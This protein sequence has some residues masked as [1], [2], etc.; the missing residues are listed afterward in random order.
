M[1][2]YSDASLIL[3]VAPEYK[4]GKI[5]SLKPTNGTGDFTVARASKKHKINSDLKLEIIN[6]DVPAFNYRSVDGCPVL[7][8]E[9]QA[10]NLI[11]YPISF[12]NA[13][14]VKSGATI[15]DNSGAGYS[16]PSV[17]FPTSAF[18]LVEDSGVA[19]QHRMYV[20]S[21]SVTTGLQYTASVYVKDFS[22]NR[23]IQLDSSGI[24]SYFDLSTLAITD[25]S[26]VGK[27]TVMADGWYRFEV[28]GVATITGSATLYVALANP[29]ETYTGDGVSGLYIFMAQFEQGS[30][31]TSPTFTDITLGD[32][33]MTTQRNADSVKNTAATGLIG[34]TEGTFLMK[35]KVLSES[36]SVGN[37]LNTGRNLTN[38]ISI[39]R[40]KTTKKIVIELYAGGVL[41]DTLTSTNTFEVG[42]SIILGFGYKTGDSALY[43]NGVAEDT[44][45]LAFAFTAALTELN[46]DDATS[47]FAFQEAMNTSYLENH[48]TRLSNT[49]LETLTTL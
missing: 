40:V 10:T 35:L 46:I 1:S 43:I 38:T 19:T 12:S 32:E 7:N 31:A 20:G 23:K 14:W 33:G 48:T 37:V 47:F 2:T 29:T 21:M 49:E 9:P 26:G 4:A 39:T 24:N 17:D 16:A 41:I 25:T 27:Y 3:P 11:T 44:S 18:K 6:N 13:Y 30:A 15:D 45:T 22:G 5:Y 28:T 8:T 36:N 42:D 34:Q